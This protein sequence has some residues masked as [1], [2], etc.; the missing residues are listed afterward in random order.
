MANLPARREQFVAY[1]IEAWALGS[2]MLAACVAVVMVDGLLPQSPALLQR[3]LVGVAMGLTAF[4]LIG[5]PW[6]QRSGAHMNPAVTLTYLLLGRITAGDAC[7]YIGA[8]F[9]GGALGVWC[10]WLLCGAALAAPDVDFVATRPGAGGPLAALCA[11]ITI[12]GLMMFT[13]LELSSDERRAHWTPYAAATLIALFITC[14][15]PLS[16]MSMNPARSFASATAA[17]HWSTLWIYFVGP[18]LGMA[19]A[20][21]LQRHRGRAGHCAKL[22]HPLDQPCIHC[23]QP[24]HTSDLPLGGHD[25][26]C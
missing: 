5:S 23:G 4:A 18:L 3:L 1:L 14:E 25:H 8:Q 24:G 17:G 9:V 22:L 20:A 13:V 15:A 2:F 6:G 10:A 19:G 7:G 26:A 21:L 16:G 11:E 12:S